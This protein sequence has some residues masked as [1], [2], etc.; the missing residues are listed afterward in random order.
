MSFKK[1]NG[2]APAKK[3][4]TKLKT[5]HTYAIIFF[6]VIVCWLLTYLI[7]AGKF[8]THTIEY[9][10]ADGGTAT[11]TVLMADTFRYYY[12]LNTDFVA[13]ALEEIS[14]DQAVMEEWEVDPEAL[15]ALMETDSSAWTQEDLDAVGISDDE[16]YSRYGEEFYD[17]SKKLHKTAGVW[18]TEDF[19]GF[20]FLNYVFEGLV[21][22]D[23]SGSAGGICALILVVGGSFGIF[24][25]TGTIDA[26]FYFFI[27]KTKWL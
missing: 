9:T 22:G 12:N 16:M 6:V 17:T 24:I 1:K 13:G 21:T 27:E 19:G 25:K 10:D 23:R 14:Q 2:Q 11:R 18:G 15:A 20:G 7:P 5:P 3:D 4:F 26:G 8:S